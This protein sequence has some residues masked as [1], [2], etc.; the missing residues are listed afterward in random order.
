VSSGSDLADACGEL[1]ALLDG[2]GASEVRNGK[3]CAGLVTVD[4]LLADADRVPS[5]R[6][7]LPKPMTPGNH[8]VF[9]A[10][11]DA[12]EL[13]RRLEASLRLAVAGHTGP[14]RGGSHGNTIAALKSIPRL[15]EA[16]SEHDRR[17]AARLLTRAAV[18]IEQLAAVDSAPKW[19]RI[20]PGPGGLPPR[21]PR[22]L[23]FSLRV[24]FLSGAVICVYPGTDGQGC[25]DL[26]GNPVRGRLDISRIDGSPVLA[27]RDGT[28]Q[29]APGAG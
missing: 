7:G 15:A 16:I 18:R 27:W 13:I 25:K 9:V 21:C 1:A 3:A 28:V 4:N 24:S 20:R 22:C 2:L 12:H 17:Q 23:T 14:A 6:R 26:D 8:A 19:E 5:V 11:T 10:I 29:A